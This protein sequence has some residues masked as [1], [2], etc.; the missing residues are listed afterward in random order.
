MYSNIPKTNVYTCHKGI[1][2]QNVS[3]LNRTNAV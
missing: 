1:V 3:I 2:F